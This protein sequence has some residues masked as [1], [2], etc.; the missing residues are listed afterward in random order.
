MSRVIGALLILLFLSSASLADGPI[1]IANKNVS[2]DSLTAKT[3]RNIFLGKERTWKEGGFI[4]PA[5]LEGGPV[6]QKFLD[7]YLQK[8]PAQFST[9]WRRIAFTG[10]S[11]K[12]N[13]FKTERQLVD[14]VAQQEGAIG[15]IGAETPTVNVKQITIAP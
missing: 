4:F 5:A 7:L 1:V 10:G 8:T 9:H 2:Q 14:Y 12:I 15:Y 13:L 3:L 6:H 11:L